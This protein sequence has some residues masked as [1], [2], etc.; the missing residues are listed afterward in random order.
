MSGMNVDAGTGGSF[1][2]AFFF[3]AAPVFQCAP[4]VLAAGIEDNRNLFFTALATLA[5]LSFPSVFLWT[6]GGGLRVLTR[7]RGVR[8]RVGRNRIDPRGSGRQSIGGFQALYAAI[9]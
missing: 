5:P 6:A 1:I 7:A 9:F 4:V 3:A 8:G 2:F